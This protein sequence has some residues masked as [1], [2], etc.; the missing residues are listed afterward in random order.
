M[1]QLRNSKTL[2]SSHLVYAFVLLDILYFPYLFH[3][4][5]KMTMVLL[6]FLPLFRKRKTYEKQS[7]SDTLLFAVL[8]VFSIFVG[9]FKNQVSTSIIVS[10]IQA[11][12]IIVYG[13]WIYY[14]FKKN[15]NYIGIDITNYLIVYLAVASIFMALYLLSPST[16]FQ[17]RPFWT[18]QRS[19]EVFRSFSENRFSFILSEPNNF[20]S[21]INGIMAFLILSN[22][23]TKS[24]KIVI[25][26]LS[27]LLVIS[28]QSISGTAVFVFLQI[29]FFI[30]LRKKKEKGITKIK[31]HIPPFRKVIMYL[32]SMICVIA[33]V[34]MIVNAE[35]LF[36]SSIIQSAT[37]RYSLYFTDSTSDFSGKRM[38]VWKYTVQTHN[39]LEYFII[40][41]AS[42][43][44][45]HSGN[46]FILYGFG[47]ITLI[48]FWRIFVFDS[49]K[50]KRAIV[51]RVVFLIV[52]STNTLIVDLRAFTLWAVLL[53]I[54]ALG[55]S[56]SENIS[57][58]K[59]NVYG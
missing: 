43:G 1:Q 32:F 51:V 46:L 34:F 29:S 2:N 21:V 44:K 25:S 53:S 37:G 15:Y 45:P 16:F 27:F 57:L 28:T 55:S 47:L 22:S 4:P 23:L 24:E 18:L 54:S 59:G 49:K 11:L 38:D 35:K 17:I 19:G 8:G 50:D 48:H 5:I 12:V 33:L 13:Y 58:R 39:L 3:L 9:I 31:K 10:N 6:P 41:D 52:F 42:V 14:Y 20:A 56:S 36:N 40:G 26:T 7:V 30:L